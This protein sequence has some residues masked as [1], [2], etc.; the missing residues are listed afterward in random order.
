MGSFQELFSVEHILA[1]RGLKTKV[2]QKGEPPFLVRHGIQDTTYDSFY[3]WFR[4]SL[5]RY[6]LLKLIDSDMRNKNLDPS[7][8]QPYSAENIRTTF[9][10]LTDCTLIMLRTPVGGDFPRL[11]N[12]C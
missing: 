9:P 3:D 11:S 1:A 6:N 7:Q 2:G 5:N 10:E 4:V 12:G 8:H